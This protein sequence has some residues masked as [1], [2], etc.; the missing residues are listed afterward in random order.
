MTSTKAAAA[1]IVVAVIVI[2]AGAFAV[3]NKGGGNDGGNN[4]APLATIGTTVDVDDAYTLSSIYSN[5]GRTLGADTAEQTTYTV[6]QK[7]GDNL[8]VEVDT[9]GQVSYETMTQDQFLD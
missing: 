9:N 7:D 3:L 8:T 1:I 5:T 4:D 2:A 6:T